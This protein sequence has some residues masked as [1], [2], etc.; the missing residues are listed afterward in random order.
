MPA[1]QDPHWQQT[2]SNSNS[3]SFIFFTWKVMNRENRVVL[4]FFLKAQAQK[5]KGKAQA[6][7]Q[8]TFCYIHT[9]LQIEFHHH[10]QLLS[11]WY[12][13]LYSP[14][15]ITLASVT[16][17]IREAIKKSRTSI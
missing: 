16:I 1:N 2:I 9:L 8:I 7:L 5:K 13:S 17:I 15:N 11:I 6:L 3:F 10:H 12:T 4:L 14:K